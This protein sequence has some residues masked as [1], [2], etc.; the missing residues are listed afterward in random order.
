M[1]PLPLDG[2]RVLDLSRL[3]PGPF[4]TWQLAAMG[5]EVWKVEDPAPGDYFRWMA[6]MLGD[7]GA[8]YVVLNR[9]KRS[10]VVDLR[11]P[12][13][14]AVL[15]RLVRCC[16]V[17]FEQFRPGVLERLGLDEGTLRAERPDLVLCRLTGYG[18]HGPRAAEAGHD[19]NYEAAAGLLA[20]S[21]EPGR[22]PPLPAVPAAD[23]AGAQMAVSAIVAAL[24]R[25]ERGFGGST[26]D[27]SMTEALAAVA[28]P[29]VAGWT[30]AGLGPERRGSLQLS[31]GL[32]NYSVYP[33]RDGGLLAFAPLE[34]KFLSRFV[35]RFGDP[36]WLSVPPEPGPEQEQ[37]RAAVATVIAARTADD[38]RAA[39]RGLD[40]CITVVSTPA[41]AV[42][43][44]QFV[45]RGVVGERS[46]GGTTAKWIES[47]LGPPI[48]GWPSAAGA[49]RD[50]ILAAAGASGDEIRSWEQAGAFGS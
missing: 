13:G 34:P 31:G 36:S 24:F 4:A 40:L 37:L 33:C 50:A 7:V 35:E 6:P 9:G 22:P 17:L 42:E 18:Q 38:W 12:A 8:G 26:I 3:L 45:G 16:D 47:P 23:M 10:I 29:F 44:P 41:E 25:R 19:M 30:A 39:L 15:L 11:T 27:L 49:D 32:A 20:M 43:D 5:A 21:G 48:E 14:R 2:V 28:A 46:A 1:V